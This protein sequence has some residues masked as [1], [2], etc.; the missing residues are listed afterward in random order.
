MD[1]I[2]ETVMSRPLEAIGKTSSTE[3]NEVA[4]LENF[5]SIPSIEKAWTS[6][7]WR[8]DDGF[9]VMVT[10]SQMNISAN[11]TRIFMS[12]VFIPDVESGN[13]K[14]CRW[15]PF[16]FELSGAALVVPSPS[17]TKLLVVRNDDV[18][19]GTSQTKLEIWGQGQ[20]LKE[21]HVPA[22]VHGSVYTDEWFQGASWSQDE[23]YIAYV[24]EEPAKPRP[25]FGQGF[26]GAGAWK[27]QGEW[28]E[29]WGETYT[30]MRRPIIF[31][32]DIESGAVQV[33]E[34]IPEDI[35]AGQVVWAPRMTTRS[36]CPAEKSILVFVG[37]TSYASN[38]NSP[39]K[40]GMVYCQNRPCH[41]YTVEAPVPGRDC[42][43]PAL[44][45]VK[46]TEGINSAVFPRFSP[47][48]KVLV[49]LSCEAAVNSGAHA[50]TNSLH[51]ISWS[52]GRVLSMPMQ[53]NDVVK[54]VQ[55]PDN[56]GFPGL[57][58]SDL[59]ANPWLADSC[60][61]LLTSMWR[62]QE[63]ILA[64]NVE[65]G[66]VERVTSCA[67]SSSWRLL[68]LQSSSLLAGRRVE[69]NNDWS[70]VNISVPSLKL[71]KK[72]ETSLKEMLYKIIQIP[73]PS[74]E[75]GDTLAEG[76]K[77]PFEA[78][79]VSRRKGTV[80]KSRL[81][82]GGGSQNKIP[83]LLLILHGGPHSIA[84]SSFSKPAAFL[85]ALGY[86][87]LYVNYRGSVG[88]G[89]EALSSLPG[90]IGRQDVG[91][92]LA[93]LNHVVKNGMADPNKVSVMGGSH[94]GFLASH[95]LGQAPDK[96]RTGILRSPVCNLAANVGTSDIPDWSYFEAFG[97]EGLTTYSEVP[98][99]SDL[100]VLYQCSPIAH[101]SK[102]KVPTLII[103]GTQD[104]RVPAISNGLPYA[105]ALRARGL[106]AKVIY[107]QDRHSLERPQTQFEGY[108]NV[109][110]WLKRFM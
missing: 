65:S 85:S 92:V 60:T 58:C 27:G 20:L 8:G 84:Q 16:P 78:V 44:P 50:A 109:G 87:L 25:E 43:V 4:L 57:Y 105:Q 110:L 97:K 101:V 61:L 35:S 9:D 74:T 42:L 13:V 47:D 14:N 77:Q 66:N 52:S 15:A 88:F 53:I 99:A 89:E 106:E 12:T 31:V 34:G 39:R 3:V 51:S 70:W 76:A 18:K 96:F 26:L 17:G 75:V 68:G 82:R 38:F 71:P 73:V 108:L 46:L 83:P 10:I 104:R 29:D 45:A 62:S 33:V 59:I 102:V 6:P 36:S 55:H 28:I 1:R 69:T 95:L 22:S 86:N 21:V 79:Y 2:S 48:G 37:W 23:D 30:G 24:A 67:S 91:D 5:L 41:L 40:L 54:I 94:G 19:N 98:S 32:A 90:N 7:S 100:S 93:A 72:V 63:V 11:A 107:V 64:I 49:F 80:T 56:D 81:G 103:V